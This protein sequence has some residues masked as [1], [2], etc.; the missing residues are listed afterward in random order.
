ML[1]S[2]PWEQRERCQERASGHLGNL[3]Y[4][5]MELDAG[6]RLGMVSNDSPNPLGKSSSHGNGESYYA[7]LGSFS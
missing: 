4:L 7:S 5:Q 1:S 2:Q 6:E 3:H